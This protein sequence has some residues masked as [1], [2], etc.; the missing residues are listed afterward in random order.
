MGVIINEDRMGVSTLVID[1]ASVANIVTVEQT[2][3]LNG[4]KVGD[5]V[6][7]SKPTTDA[8]LGVAGARVSAANTLAITF[9]NPTAAPVNAGSETWQIFW[10][11]PEKTYASA[12]PA[13]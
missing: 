11:R 2:F 6:A 8:G 4:L 1:P 9:V 7:V 13:L 5:F 3:T 10:F 12:V